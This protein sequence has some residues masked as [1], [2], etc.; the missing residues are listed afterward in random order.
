MGLVEIG[1][2]WTA[3]RRE[4]AA[5]NFVRQSNW[6]H[7]SPTQASVGHPPSVVRERTEH[8]GMISYIRRVLCTMA[9]LALGPFSLADDCHAP[10]YAKGRIYEESPRSALLNISIPPNDFTPAKLICLAEH[11]RKEYQGRGEIVISI[12]DRRDAARNAAPMSEWN[13]HRAEYN[14]HQHAAYYY[15]E[16]KEQEEITLYP[17]SP[18]GG[19]KQTIPLPVKAVPECRFQID[20]RCLLMLD[21]ADYPWEARKG[22]ISGLVSLRATMGASGTLHDVTVTNAESDSASSQRL[23]AKAAKVNLKSW[24]FEAGSHDVPLR[25]TYT[26]KLLNSP[27]FERDVE[28]QLSLPNDVVV[29]ANPAN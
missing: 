9:I 22:K 1:S 5:G 16:S 26:Y 27:T 29:M 15:D 19:L 18:D 25:I 4:R 10:R 23:L 17:A 2:E 13:K 3:R 11:F 7:S 24:R 8:M 21:Q 12:F 28:V 14:S 20:R 6:P